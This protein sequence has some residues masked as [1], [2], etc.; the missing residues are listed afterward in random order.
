MSEM[1]R[2]KASKIRRV[3]RA[4]FQY[5]LKFSL[6]TIAKV[7]VFGRENLSGLTREKSRNFIVVAN[8]SSHFDAPIILKSLPRKLARK[9]AVAAA[10]DYFFAKKSSAILTGIFLNTFPVERHKDLQEKQSMKSYTWENFAND[11][12]KKSR[13]RHKGL[14]RELLAN[15]IPLLILPEGTRSRN[16]EM[17]EFREGA[18][19]LALEFDALIVPVAI[20]GAFEAWPANAK[21]WRKVPRGEREKKWDARPKILV[22]FGEVMESRDFVKDQN[23]SDDEVAK[24]LTKK[25]REE[26]ERM[27]G[28]MRILS[29][30]KISRKLI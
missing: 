23:E 13:K 28:E 14:A 2:K 24:K 7:E 12:E 19:R 17:G 5:L 9:V 10:A 27:C 25:M 20:V 6:G 18:A 30:R 1:V 15:G 26:I 3:T 16:G 22:K 4:P 8:H 11:D 21:T 29:S